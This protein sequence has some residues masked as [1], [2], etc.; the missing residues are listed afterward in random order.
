MKTAAQR[1]GLIRGFGFRVG[2]AGT[3]LL[4]LLPGRSAVAASEAI[5]APRSKASREIAGPGLDLRVAKFTFG[6]PASV[7]RA[8]FTKVTVNDK[9]TPEKRFGFDT[10]TTAFSTTR[11]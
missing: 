1:I 2:W 3:M 10:S 7:T 4:P 5:P 8:G 9:F 11:S 6:T